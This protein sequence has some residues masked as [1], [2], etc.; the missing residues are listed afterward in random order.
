MLSNRIMY[1]TAPPRPVPLRVMCRALL[2]I[3]GTIGAAFLILGLMFTLAFGGGFNPIDE[4]R[5]ALS[6]T[7]AQGT[8]TEVIV[9]NATEN[10]VPVYEYHFTFHTLDGQTFTARSYA[11]GRRWSPED[12][13]EVQ[14]VP[15]EP[16]IAT[17][18]ETRRSQFTPWVFSLVLLFPAIGAAL[19]VTA[20]LGGLRQV[21]LLRHG[22][23]ARAQALSQ[24]MTNVRVNNVPVIKYTYEFEAHDGETYLGSSKALPSERIGDEAQ[25]P[26][27]YLPSNPGVSTLVDG[28]PLRHPLDVDGAGQWITHESIWPVVWYGLIWTA[29]IALVTF[30]LLRILGTL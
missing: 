2:G 10:N 26:V 7:T 9:T 11:T 22:E 5:L 25:E 24:E 23:I 29:I 16:T 14:Y 28:L 15:D 1:L 13:V 19:F 12:R 21:M 20:T 27:L 4:L 30:G 17:M 18:E 6:T 3:T 8:V